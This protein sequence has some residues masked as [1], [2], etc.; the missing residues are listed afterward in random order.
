MDIAIMSN[1]ILKSKSFRLKGRLYT[2]T[3]LQLVEVDCAV[4]KKQIPEVIATAPRL[5]DKTPIVI[6]CSIINPDQLD[7]QQ[8]C[9]I[10][11]EHNL[12]PIAIQGGN[13]Y[14]E[15][16][17]ICQGLAIVNTTS[18]HDKPIGESSDSQEKF[19]SSKMITTPVRS[20][21]QIV[22]KNSDLIIVA[23]VSHG[24]ELLADGS[25]HVYGALRGRALA[26]IA[27]DKSARIFCQTMDA[28]LVAIAGYYRL[29]EAIKPITGP[30][31]I[32]LEND[33]IQ[34][35]SL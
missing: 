10:L 12:V 20:G 18:T 21:Q 29:R 22:S 35:E 8:L 19:V 1:N 32:Y 28:E 7:L 5:F 11:K 14:L 34:I 9:Q 27:G 30:C 17:A 3:V 26:G 6:D 25:I 31:Q 15:T 16:I 4:L 13:P 2:L 24:A 23:T 33:V